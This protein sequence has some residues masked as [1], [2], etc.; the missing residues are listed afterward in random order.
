MKS[1]LSA[2]LEDVF[3]EFDDKPVA[4]ASIAQVHKATLHNGDI[5]AV[6]LLR[7]DIARRMQ[8]D[9]TFFEAM[10]KLV[11]R[12]T[13]ALSR[14]RLVAAV[15]EFQQL[16]EI[17][18]DLRMEAAAGRLA[19]NLIHDT[20]IRIPRMYSEYCAQDML[21]TQWVD[22]LRLD[23]VDGLIARGHDID[24]LTNAAASSFLIK[25]SEM[26]I[27]MLICIPAMYLWIMMGFSSRLILGLWA[28]LP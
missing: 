5:V 9:V 16:C 17:E 13:P 2:K 10:A 12:I 23:D 26:V 27:F 14:L 3:A 21:V 20:G 25:Y 22:G 24:A 28:I 4:A 6:K 1:A 7:P 15:E 11:S 19:E 8:K 18:L